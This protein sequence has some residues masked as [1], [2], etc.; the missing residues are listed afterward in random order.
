MPKKKRGKYK[1]K[2]SKAELDELRQLHQAI[3]K[4]NGRLKYQALIDFY[5]TKF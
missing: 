2:P 1:T 3:D 4:S 5:Y